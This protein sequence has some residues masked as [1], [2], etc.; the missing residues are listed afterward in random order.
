MLSRR[1]DELGLD[2][3]VESGGTQVNGSPTSP[4]D[5]FRVLSEIGIDMPARH[6]RQIT[7]ETIQSADLILTGSTGHRQ[8]VVASNIEA[9]NRTFTLR[10]FARL[11]SVVTLETTDRDALGDDLLRGARI[12]RSRFQP[13]GQSDDV[14]DPM[15]GNIRRFRA[16]RDI[17]QAA[18]TEMT[19]PLAA[20]VSAAAARQPGSLAGHQ[21]IATPGIT[22][23]RRNSF[24]KTLLPRRP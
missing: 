6:A 19:A 3:N 18:G 15:G 22:V 16:C 11:T 1:L 21:P 7:S 9:L 23:S 12:A 20:A 8:S 14:P 24:G 4:P 5:V 13:G 2:W 17:I 10:Q